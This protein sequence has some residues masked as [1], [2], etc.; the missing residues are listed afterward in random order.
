MHYRSESS[1]VANHF[2]GAR[3]V[4]PALVRALA[5]ALVS[6]LTVSI[7]RANV[8]SALPPA[9]ESASPDAG[10]PPINQS[11]GGDLSYFSQDLSTILRLRYSTES[12]GQDGT[13]NFDL[14]TFQI[15]T[16]DD[17]AAFFDGQVTLNE[18]DGVGFN[19]GLGYRWIAEVE[20]LTDAATGP[21]AP[22]V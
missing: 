3:R 12:Y 16:M 7:G 18:S 22:P 4:R 19:V 21:A 6:A 11:G 10:A 17:T 14:G 15:V 2:N 13:G 8:P 20:E 5:L 1:G 9:M